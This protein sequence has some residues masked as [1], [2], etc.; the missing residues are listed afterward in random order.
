[1][2]II[3]YH[4]K[5]ILHLGNVL[6]C[7]FIYSLEFFILVFSTASHLSL[8]YSFLDVLFLF[9]IILLSIDSF[10]SIKNVIF[11]KLVSSAINKRRPPC[12]IACPVGWGCRILWL[13]L[14]RGVRPLNKCP[15]YETK[16][17][18]CDVPLMLELWWMQ[19]TFSLPSLAG[20][21]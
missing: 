14:C 5:K 10:F 16:P 7:F 21:L 19:S 18:D 13:Y 12:D 4:T 9:L 3:N 2:N 1:M 15:G 20:P 8:F 11:V 17:S 6:I